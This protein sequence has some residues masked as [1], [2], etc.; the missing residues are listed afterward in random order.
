MIMDDF[1]V[2]TAFD[3]GL[4]AVTRFQSI[5]RWHMVD[6]TRAQSIGEHSANV[7]LL[8]YHIAH[9]VPNEFF[10]DPCKVLAP[11]L[12]HDLPEVFMGDIPTHTKKYL[13]GV[14]ELE[15]RLTPPEYRYQSTD[16]IDLLIKICDL[17]D[18]IRFIERF[19]VDRVAIFATEGLRQQLDVK[20]K[21]ARAKWPEPVWVV[22][23]DKINDY[24]YL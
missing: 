19:G 17:A 4:E 18:G 12:M 8:A 15:E 21:H 13:S 3:P 2:D 16:D 23:E 5:R 11:G 10:G 24:L 1:R 22:V 6:T 9:K 14:Q 7:A 20:L